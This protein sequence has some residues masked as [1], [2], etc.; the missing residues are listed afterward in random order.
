[1]SAE[2]GLTE[3]FPPGEGAEEEAGA[4]PEVVAA[5]LHGPEDAMDKVA[6][7][8]DLV[9]ELAQTDGKVGI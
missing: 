9:A 7:F 6:R 3:I 8:E 2:N 5:E 4:P 1:M